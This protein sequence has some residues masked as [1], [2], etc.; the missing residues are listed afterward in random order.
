[1][2][3]AEYRGISD[4][5]VQS[6]VTFLRSVP[7]VRSETPKSQYGKPVTSYGPPVSNVPTPPKT[8]PV[9]YGRYLAVPVGHCMECHTL[10]DANRHPDYANKLGA[11]GNV[12]RGPWGESL[13]RNLTPHESGLKDWSDEQVARAIREGIDRHGNRLKPPMGFGYYKNMSDEE[14]R[15]IIAYLR[16]LKPLPMAGG[17]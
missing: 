9:A 17:G 1:M 16:S 3:V 11:G 15:A 2:A 5:D 13:S 12:F 14:V 10:R 4:D 8:D 6:I 7:A